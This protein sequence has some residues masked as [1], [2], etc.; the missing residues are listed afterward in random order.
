MTS[1]IQYM[2]LLKG[3]GTHICYGYDKFCV[4]HSFIVII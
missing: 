4:S 2:I 1:D 3:V